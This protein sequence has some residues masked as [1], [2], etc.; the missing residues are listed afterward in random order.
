MFIRAITAIVTIAIDTMLW[1]AILALLNALLSAML[2][3][4]PIVCAIVF[5]DMCI[6]L[7]NLASE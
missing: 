7:H 2:P 3:V 6:M 5:I 1:L 4:M